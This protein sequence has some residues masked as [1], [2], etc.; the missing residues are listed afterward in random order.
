MPALAISQERI[1]RGFKMLD[2]QWNH[3]RFPGAWPP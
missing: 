1:C 3:F 2:T